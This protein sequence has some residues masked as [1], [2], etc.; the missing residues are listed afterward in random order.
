MKLRS[1]VMLLTTASVLVS[2]LVLIGLVNWQGRVLQ[3]ETDIEMDSMTRQQVA[4]VT[5]GLY[6]MARNQHESVLREI[7]ADLRVAGRIL[8]DMGGVSIGDDLVDWTIVNQFTKAESKVQL[9]QMMVG[10]MWLGKNSD[11]GNMSPV[12]DDITSLTGATCTVFQR[13]PGTDDMLRVSTTVKKLDGKRAIGTFIPKV[14][15]GKP[16]GVVAAVLNGETFFG[17]AFVVNAWYLT[18]YQPIKNRKDEVVGILYVGVAQD[19]VLE[20]TKE[21][22]AEVVVGKTG[23]AWALGAS[24]Q[25]AGKFVVSRGRQSDGE[26][27]LGTKGR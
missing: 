24:G 10:G 20:T 3:H 23:N 11:F 25:E 4:T 9:P 19:T 21:A 6:N 17:R 22:I 14:H 27:I 1:K 7:E 16:N 26:N 13:V 12:V 15:D 5:Q 8:R 18:A 2:C